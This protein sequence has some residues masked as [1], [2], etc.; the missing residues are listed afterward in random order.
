MS[1]KTSL[2]EYTQEEIDDNGNGVYGGKRHDEICDYL[3]ETFGFN[4]EQINNI[5]MGIWMGIESEQRVWV[6]SQKK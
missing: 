4:D 6:E 5:S 2:D 3:R 1:F